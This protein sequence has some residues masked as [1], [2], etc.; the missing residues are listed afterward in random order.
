MSKRS[1]YQQPLGEPNRHEPDDAR[2]LAPPHPPGGSAQDVGDDL[3]R[4][5]RGRHPGEASLALGLSGEFLVGGHVERAL[6]RLEFGAVRGDVGLHAAGHDGED[7]D[8]KG[9][10][11]ETE[12]FAEDLLGCLGGRV[13]S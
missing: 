4:E 12:G 11:L 6:P 10:H 5:D 13:H 2:H 1:T 9:F 7:F 8:A 3:V